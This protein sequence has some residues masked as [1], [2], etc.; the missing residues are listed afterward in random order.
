MEKYPPKPQNLQF[1]LRRCKTR[2]YCT[3]KS[4]TFLG[5][6]APLPFVVV[7]RWQVWVLIKVWNSLPK[8]LRQDVV[9][10]LENLSVPQAHGTENTQLTNETQEQLNR[11]AYLQK[12]KVNKRCYFSI[13]ELLGWDRNLTSSW[14]KF[15]CLGQKFNEL[16]ETY[17]SCSLLSFLNSVR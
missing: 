9:H 1:S 16:R 10:T 4:E 14:S 2:M 5:K 15:L 13:S 3:W 8:L 17:P 12:C 11:E 6:P 7:Q